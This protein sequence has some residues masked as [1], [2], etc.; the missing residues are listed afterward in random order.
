[1]D[2]QQ[3]YAQKKGTV[4]DALR[5]IRSNDVVCM[6]GECNEA[7]VFAQNLHKIAPEVKNV[8]IHKGRT[9]NFD[10]VQGGGMAGRL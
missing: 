7:T 8:R 6:S 1:M 4:D 3:L 9:G 5:L 2:Y 10:F